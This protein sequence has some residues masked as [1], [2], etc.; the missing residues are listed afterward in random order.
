MRYGEHVCYR[1]DHL[2]T[3]KRP[4]DSLRGGIT[5]C[6][7]CVPAS[8]HQSETPGHEINCRAPTLQNI[9]DFSDSWCERRGVGGQA[10]LDV[11]R[12]G[13]D[14]VQASFQGVLEFHGA[15][16]RSVCQREV[17]VRS[18]EAGRET[19]IAGFPHR[20]VSSTTASSTPQCAA[21]TSMPSSAMTV[22]STS[23]HTACNANR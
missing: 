7:T 2:G 4:S 14:D 11:T 18:D 12:G 22:L 15:T 20:F 16:H 5:T 10:I 21:R 3:S 17:R 23:K 8:P 1:L 13:L 6:E 19:R 9:D